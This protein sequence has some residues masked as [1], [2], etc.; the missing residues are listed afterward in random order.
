MA[1]ELPPKTA[2]S[3]RFVWSDSYSWFTSV[4]FC[5]FFFLAQFLI[6]REYNEVIS[7]PVRWVPLPTCF[8][9]ASS[10]IAIEMWYELLVSKWAGI[11]SGTRRKKKKK[12]I[13]F[14]QVELHNVTSKWSAIC[15]TK[16]IKRRGE[17]YLRHSKIYSEVGNVQIERLA[18]LVREKWTQRKQIS[19]QT[20]LSHFFHQLWNASL[21][22]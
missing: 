22:G 1:V 3:S 6:F 19:A 11:R 9:T 20:Y 16:S 7:L 12:E 8:P 17:K 21:N 14:Q 5:F 10:N 13:V 18:S 15:T 2:N 4:C